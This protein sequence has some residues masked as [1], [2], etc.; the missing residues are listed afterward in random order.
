MINF[1]ALL[2]RALRHDVVIGVLEHYEID[3]IYEFDRTH[4]NMD[5]LYWATASGAGFQFRFNQNQILDTVFLYVKGCERFTPISRS[6]IDVAIYESFDQAERA[7]STSGLPFKQSQGSPG[8]DMY[9][10]W[11]KIDFGTYAV[12]Y[13]FKE[14]MLLMITISL[15]DQG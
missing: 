12:H 10:C 5:D 8:S 11:I 6:A 15:E 14:G 7:F 3:V 2:G 1:T 4:E 9:K 13:Q